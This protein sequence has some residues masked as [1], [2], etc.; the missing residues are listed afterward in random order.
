MSRVVFAKAHSVI[1]HR[2]V[3]QH[4]LLTS[5]VYEGKFILPKCVFVVSLSAAENRFTKWPQ[6]V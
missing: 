1:I 2:S 3:E 4:L 6:L 5:D